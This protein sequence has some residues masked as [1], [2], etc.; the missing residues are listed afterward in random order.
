[1]SVNPTG[2]RASALG[3]VTD[4]EAHLAHRLEATGGKLVAAL[5]VVV[6]RDESGGV[7]MTGSGQAVARH[8]AEQLGP[9]HRA[10]VARR[11]RE[12]ADVLDPP[13]ERPLEPLGPI[14]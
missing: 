9:R 12:L 10:D 7:M 11:L 6:V 13:P 2:T 8:A 4:L 5:R 1:M 3:I 14:A